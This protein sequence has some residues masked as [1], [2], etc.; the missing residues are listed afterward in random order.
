[1][2]AEQK[3]YLFTYFTIPGFDL[4]AG[5]RSNMVRPTLTRVPQLVPAPLPIDAKPPFGPSGRAAVNLPSFIIHH[6]MRD[7]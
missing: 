6:S 3:D 4:E 2:N 7:Q 1:M 5:G